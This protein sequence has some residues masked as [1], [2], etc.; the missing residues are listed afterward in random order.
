MLKPQDIV[1]IL[2]LL[3]AENRGE[4]TSYPSLSA[5]TGLS[6]SEAHAAIRRA[7]AAGLVSP[8]LKEN[9][10]GFSWT[11]SRGGLDEFASHAIRYLWPVELGSEQRGIPTGWAVSGVNSGPNAVLEGVPWVW[12]FPTGTARGVEMKPL[13]RSV[14]EAAARDELFHQALA[15]IDLAR[16]PQQRLR[17]L[18]VEWLQ[19]HILRKP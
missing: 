6:A 9:G 11:V 15:A 4:G 12:K 17:R 5:W 8:A 19:S 1:V 7:V 13:Y 10:T 14:P 2:R 16:A 3:L 18:G